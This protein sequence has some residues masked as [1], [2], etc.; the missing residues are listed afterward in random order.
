MATP[1]ASSKPSRVKK[2]GLLAEY[3]SAPAIYKACEKIRDA[4]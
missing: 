1:P 4:G 3:D 2:F